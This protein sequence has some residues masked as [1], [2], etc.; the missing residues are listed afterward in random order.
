MHILKLNQTV[1]DTAVNIKISNGGNQPPKT[2]LWLKRS[3][4]TYSHTRLKK[5]TQNPWQSTQRYNQKRENF[6]FNSLT[7]T[8]FLMP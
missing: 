2:I 4:I 1:L 5:I 6:S 3:S 7:I 8:G